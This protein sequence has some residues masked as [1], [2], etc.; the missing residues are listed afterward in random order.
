MATTKI[1][2]DHQYFTSKEEVFSDIAKMD[3]WP[4]TSVHRSTP[5][6]TLHS[7]SHNTII[8]I[9]DGSVLVYEDGQKTPVPCWKAAK[10]IIPRGCIHTIAIPEHS[11]SITAY[12]D[13]ES[14]AHSEKIYP[15]YD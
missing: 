5:T 15:E 7:H 6:G 12:P 8:Y 11:I 3:M 10:I 9:F 13:P 14:A 2:I 1:E 4:V